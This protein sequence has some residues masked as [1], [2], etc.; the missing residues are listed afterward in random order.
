MF[1]LYNCKLQPLYSG[2]T[3]DDCLEELGC[4]LNVNG[5]TSFDTIVYSDDSIGIIARKT[6]VLLP[7][8]IAPSL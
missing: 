3:V 4:L 2:L 5:L 6:G 8:S 7:Y 1:T